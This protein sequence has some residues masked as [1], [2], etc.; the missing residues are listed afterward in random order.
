MITE[1]T[2]DGDDVAYDNLH[3]GSIEFVSLHSLPFGIVLFFALLFYAR[4][5]LRQI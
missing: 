3:I 4:I 5:I 2:N 1:A